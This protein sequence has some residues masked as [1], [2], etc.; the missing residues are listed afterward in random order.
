MRPVIEQH[1]VDDRQKL[2]QF[3]FSICL[4][5][6]KASLLKGGFFLDLRNIEGKRY[7]ELAV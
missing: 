1:K 6:S 7:G 5:T 3:T 4:V 2:V